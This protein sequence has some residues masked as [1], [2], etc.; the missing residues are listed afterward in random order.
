MRKITVGIIGTGFIRPAH[1]EAIRRLGFVEVVA[2]AESNLASA[3]KKAQRLGIPKAY[4]DYRELLK[5]PDIEVVHNCTPNYLHGFNGMIW[6]L[7]I[8]FMAV[9][10]RTG[11]SMKRTIIGDLLRKLAVHLGL[12]QILALTG[13]I[14]FNMSQVKKWLK[15]LPIWQRSFRSGKNLFTK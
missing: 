4:G 9:I 3:E 13:A 2:I 5:D 8:L 11:C 15:Y 7:F 14:P 1:I 10:C 12:L 6:G